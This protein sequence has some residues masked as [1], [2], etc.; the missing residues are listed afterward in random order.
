MLDCL[1][2]MSL[3]LRKWG[4]RQRVAPTIP[5]AP[6]G[7]SAF[8]ALTSWGLAASVMIGCS[9]GR[10]GVSQNVAPATVPSEKARSTP[11]AD[12]AAANSDKALAL[13]GALQAG[14]PEKATVDFNPTLQEK[15]PSERLA[16]VW[17]ALERQVGRAVEHEPPRSVD[18]RILIPIRFER[19]ALEMK[20]KF[21]SG[22][23][24]GLLF[25]PYEG[26]LWQPPE[27]VRAEAF[28][29]RE[30]RVGEP[31]FELP[32][33][34]TL[35]RG[36]PAPV[37]VLVH[38]S[39]PSDR[40][41]TQGPNKLFKDLAWGLATRGVAVLR[42]EKRTLA[43][44]QR[45]AAMLA[46][47]R[48]FTVKEEVVDD[49]LS[50]LRTVRALRETAS[51]PVFVAGHSLGAYLGPRIAS[52]D[53]ALAGLILLA[54]PSRPLEEMLVDQS[55]YLVRVDGTI[56]SDE[57]A[58][59]QQNREQASAVREIARTR[60]ADGARQ[61]FGLPA[62]YWLDLAGYDPVASATQLRCP[63]LVLQGERDY[64][65]ARADFD[66]WTRAIAG[67]AR[68]HSRSYA[69]LNHL[70]MPGQ[71]PSVPDEY[72]RAGH[73]DRSV[74]DDIAAFVKSAT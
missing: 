4:A 2:H 72:Q 55:E 57:Q 24:A 58:A 39:G 37:V 23:V 43:H 9:A 68:C 21:A 32:A 28:E 17:A 61:P 1:R 51:S 14:D 5:W 16:T 65:V 45:V 53:G 29:E 59:L 31:G 66:S 67:K 7:S 64:Q 25:E 54:G 11:E 33:V 15:L 44:R 18:D 6:K 22:K 30:L 56:S 34:L 40:D 3:R 27:Y 12:P 49:A 20:V 50:A 8:G 19:A 47:G 62:S 41:A 26:E 52:Q 36:G 13:L 38:G 60:K 48:T 74:I 46:E 10:A 63:I 42:Y 71:G 70:F 35:P 73:V 69:A